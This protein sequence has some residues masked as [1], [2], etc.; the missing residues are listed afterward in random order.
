M[1]IEWIKGEHGYKQGVRKGNYAHKEGSNWYNG[2]GG[3]HMNTDMELNLLG[4]D[5][6]G[7]RH[8]FDLKGYFVLALGRKKMTDSLY[9]MIEKCLPLEIEIDDSTGQITSSC[10][11]VIVDNYNKIK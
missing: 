2:Y 1:E 7:V 9:L 6:S 3:V 5:G 11:A 8:T 10:M 4:V